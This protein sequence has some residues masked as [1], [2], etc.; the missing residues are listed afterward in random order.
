[1]EIKI[2]IV[3]LVKLGWR[4]WVI[5]CSH[6]AGW[7][8]PEWNSHTWAQAPGQAQGRAVLPSSLMTE[9]SWLD[10]TLQTGLGW[11]GPCC[12]LLLLTHL[13]GQ[14]LLLQGQ[15]RASRDP[16]INLPL[17]TRV[18]S[19]CSQQAW[20]K[21]LRP[22][23]AWFRSHFRIC[24]SSVHKNPWNYGFHVSLILLSWKK[25]PFLHNLLW[26]MLKDCRFST[27]AFAGPCA[28]RWSSPS[29][30]TGA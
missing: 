21:S 2:S 14:T 3:L 27:V 28:R 29:S 13:S 19:K 15:R 8:S 23:N 24:I 22:Q 1:M 20:P 26:E 9:V 6:K 16:L 12:S 4:T 18:E 5:F 7:H 10:C 25:T 11:T 30:C 17:E